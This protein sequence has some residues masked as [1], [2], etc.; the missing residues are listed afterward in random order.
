MNSFEL[1]KEL[2]GVCGTE[3]IPETLTLKYQ[4]N[5]KGQLLIR[6]GKIPVNDGNNN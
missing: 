6:N 4:V 1:F 5:C 3:G 2:K